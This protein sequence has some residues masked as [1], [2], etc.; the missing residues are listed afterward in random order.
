MAALVSGLHPALDSLGVPLPY[1]MLLAGPL[2]LA[3]ALG[4]MWTGAAAAF[5]TL[6]IGGTLIVP[7]LIRPE[8]PP[9]RTGLRLLQHNLYFEN[10]A[11]RTCR[12]GS[13]A[14]T[15]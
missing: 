12:N 13:R 9:A 2:V 10:P 3:L 6:L 11:R 5:L 15:S 8:G 7:H 4:R 1:A 14:T